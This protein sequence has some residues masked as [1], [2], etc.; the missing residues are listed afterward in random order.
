A[1]HELVQPQDGADRAIAMSDIQAQTNL[2]FVRQ[3]LA[4]AEPPPRSAFG[5][6]AWVQRN[7][8]ASVGDTIL[9]ILALVLLVWP[10]PPLVRWAFVDAVWS[11]PDREVCVSPEAGAC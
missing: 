2:T 4:K 7:L 1:V 8:F 10:P 3:E 11:G 6:V 5:P 9:T